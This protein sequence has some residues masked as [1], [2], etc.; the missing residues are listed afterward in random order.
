MSAHLLSVLLKLSLTSLSSTWLKTTQNSSTSS[1]KSSHEKQQIS[2]PLSQTVEHRSYSAKRIDMYLTD[3]VPPLYMYPHPS[4]WSMEYL[5]E[6]V[7]RLKEI[8]DEINLILA[9]PRG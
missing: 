3:P 6:R 9:M 1:T 8:L 5:Q 7:G 2:T 4:M